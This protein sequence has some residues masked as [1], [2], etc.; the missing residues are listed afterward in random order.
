MRKVLI[1][2][3]ALTAS[4]YAVAQ[5]TTTCM[6]LGSGMTSC[7]SAGPQGHSTATCM[8]HGS[9][10]SCNSMDHF[11]SLDSDQSH[12]DSGAILGKG[13]ADFVNG[14]KERNFR[15]KV[16]KML[17]AGNC[18]D[19]TTYAYEKGRIEFASAIAQR[20]STTT[21][22]APAPTY[23]RR[24]N[25]PYE[26]LAQKVEEWA[27]I[28]PANFVLS[29]SDSLVGRSFTANG[30]SLIIETNAHPDSKPD[31]IERV[32]CANRAMQPILTSGATVVVPLSADEVRVTRDD[33]GI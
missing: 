20:C 14:I 5:T 24:A 21:V 4:S 9:I 13:I 29:E 32:V 26:E 30:G 6:D 18:K 25:L 2:L 28:F 15:K 22:A 12:P 3:A 33:C 31:G 16:G 11:S 23:S 19:A 17:A 27:G 10:V 1:T 8:R 7:N